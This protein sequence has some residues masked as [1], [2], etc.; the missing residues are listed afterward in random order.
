MEGV[1]HVNVVQVCGCGLVGDVDRMA[2]GKVPDR[3]GLELGVA[4][5]N[6]AFVLLVQLAKAYCH[7]SAAGAGS[8]DNYQRLGCFYVVVLTEAFVRINKGYVVGVAFNCVVIVHLDVHVLQALAVSIC[9]CLAVVVGYDN[10]VDAKAAGDKLIPKAQYIYVVGDSKVAAY[11]VL[12]NIYRTDD[13]YNLCVVLHLHQHLK[14][15]VRLKAGKNAAGMEVV[16]EFSA[17]FHV[18][19]VAEFG[20]ALLDVLRLNLEILAVVEPVLHNGLS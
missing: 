19:F 4:G 2:E 3:E 16:E 8:R 1:D 13:D 20:D 18:K 15:A 12:F 11:L 5:L 17:E 7:L 14:L 9:A 10:T 6:A